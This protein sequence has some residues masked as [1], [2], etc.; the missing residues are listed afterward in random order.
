[1][2]PPPPD[3]PSPCCLSRRNKEAVAEESEIDDK[4]SAVLYSIPLCVIQTT[5]MRE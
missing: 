5:Q 2:A 1:M 4:H 3:D